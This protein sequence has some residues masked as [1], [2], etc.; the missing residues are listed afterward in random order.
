M[1]DTIYWA[2]AR[3]SRVKHVLGVYRTEADARARCEQHAADTRQYVWGSE[4][5][6]GDG[7]HRYVL[8]TAATDGSDPIPLEVLGYAY[9]D[10]HYRWRDASHA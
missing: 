7:W 9:G 1:S 5:F 10:L 3:G 6:I 2:E 8:C 4:P